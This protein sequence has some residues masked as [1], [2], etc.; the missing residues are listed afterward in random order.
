[1]EATVEEKLRAL[2]SLQRVDSNIDQINKTRGELP[3]E[4]SDLEDE[5]T[6]LE[7]RVSKITA[8]I[9]DTQTGNKDKEAAIDESKKL[10]KKYDKQLMDVK[11][12][13][14]YDSLNKEL[15]LQKLEILAN[16]KKIN[17]TIEDIEQYKETL[18]ASK[19]ALSERKK[20]LDIKNKELGDII[21]ETEKEEK[22]FEK[23][24]KK[25]ANLVEE[26]LLK[27]YKRI[28][29]AAR[30]GLAVVPV[31]RDACGGCFNKI[32]PQRQMDIRTRQKIIVCEHCGRIL[33][34]ADI[35]VALTA[36]KE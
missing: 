31:E 25:A 28:R 16:E 10:I 34:D 30:N 14:E 13:R 5:L 11:N 24:S 29:E 6:G 32:P 3:M 1:M 17:H 9:K 4:V 2:Y 21:K 18:K 22:V 12:S 8:Q 7:T 26:R 36:V 33:V 35:D 27:A 15:E 20:D 23:K 19:E